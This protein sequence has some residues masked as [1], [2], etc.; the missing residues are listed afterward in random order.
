MAEAVATPATDPI[1]ATALLAVA[2]KLPREDRAKIAEGLLVSLDES[3]TAGVAIAWREESR[4]RLEQIKDG[5]AVL[6]DGVDV[7]KEAR[8]LVGL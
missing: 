1:D 3:D 2:L 5:T 4:R 6:H 8:Q 7:L